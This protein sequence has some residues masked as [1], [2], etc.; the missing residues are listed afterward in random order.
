MLKELSAYTAGAVQERMA[1]AHASPSGP[2][3]PTRARPWGSHR[4][5]AA[6][7]PGGA[8]P[9]N[10]LSA[11]GGGRHRAPFSPARPWGRPRNMAAKRM[12]RAAPTASL[13]P[14]TRAAIDAAAGVAPAGACRR[15][16]DGRSN[17]PRP[18]SFLTGAAKCA[19]RLSS[20][21]V[22]GVVKKTSQKLPR[23]MSHC[24]RKMKQTRPCGMPDDMRQR[25][26]QEQ[27]RPDRPRNSQGAPPV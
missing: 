1:P 12:L 19:P 13:A 10:P 16:R 4:D 21:P 2:Q 23:G 3:A 11:G 15:R 6:T 18:R 22:D 20:F 25:R 14:L 26:G 5:A 17:A 7:P 8:R 9:A 24:V 27:S